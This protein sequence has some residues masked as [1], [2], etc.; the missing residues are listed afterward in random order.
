ML[1][2][3]TVTV[4]DGPAS[5]AKLPPLRPSVLSAAPVIAPLIVARFPV[6]GI[7][8]PDPDCWLGADGDEEPHAPAPSPTARS[9][10][11]TISFLKSTLPPYERV[12]GSQELATL[13]PRDV[14]RTRFV[15]G[16]K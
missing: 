5:D 2:P 7:S 15:I 14:C 13:M 8:D 12:E 16:C 11:K 4:S 6:V 1:V 9:D 3:T 10:I